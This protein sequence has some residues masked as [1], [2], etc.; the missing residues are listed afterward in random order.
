MVNEMLRIGQSL[1][2]GIALTLFVGSCSDSDWADDTGPDQPTLSAFLSHFATDSQ[3]FNLRVLVRSPDSKG[4]ELLALSTEGGA[5]V[6]FLGSQAMTRLC[7][8]VVTEQLFTVTSTN[9][10]PA[11]TVA[12]GYWQPD[13]GWLS[14]DA[15]LAAACPDLPG[16][17]E[18]E[19]ILV[20]IPPVAPAGGGDAGTTADG[21]DALVEDVASAGSEDAS[22]APEAIVGAD[23]SDE[24]R[25]SDGG[26]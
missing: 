26:I 23:G 7:V 1:F 16:F 11:V 24:G 22:A 18:K 6:G 9:G 20:T 10:T 14:V 4:H 12:V 2:V 19:S 5:T 21:E 13:G 8:P 15:G 25:E 17:H 3:D